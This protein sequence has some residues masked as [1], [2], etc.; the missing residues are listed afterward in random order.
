MFVWGQILQTV[1]LI[2]VCMFGLGKCVSGGVVTLFT[3]AGQ[4]LLR[5]GWLWQ[6]VLFLMGV[7]VAGKYFTE[8]NNKIEPM[9][10]NETSFKHLNPVIVF[11]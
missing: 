9:D 3:P 4:W 1:Y 2:G 6:V 7:I 11:Y 8:N 5:V 10:E